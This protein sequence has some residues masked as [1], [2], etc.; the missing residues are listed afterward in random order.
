MSRIKGMYAS[1]LASLLEI[2][3][4]FGHGHTPQLRRDMATHQYPQRE[5]EACSILV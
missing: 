3:L 2:H 1:L 4:E 5:L